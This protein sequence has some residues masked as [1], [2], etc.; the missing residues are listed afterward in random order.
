MISYEVFFSLVLL[1]LM[2]MAGSAN[3]GDFVIQQQ[4]I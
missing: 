4:A 2:L 3:L 1:T